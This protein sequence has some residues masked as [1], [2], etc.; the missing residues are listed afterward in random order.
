MASNVPDPE[1]VALTKP[2]KFNGVDAFLTHS[3]S[4]DP[5]VG[6]AHLAPPPHDVAARNLLVHTHRRPTLHPPTRRPTYVPNPRVRFIAEVGEAPAVAR[7]VR[8][9]TRTGAHRV[10][11]E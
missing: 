10:D 5:K 6:A 11:R 9:R 4:D 2:A 8:R 7:G 1:L 3:W